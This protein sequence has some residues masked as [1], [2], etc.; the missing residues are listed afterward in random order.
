M[1]VKV[2]KL[3]DVRGYVTNVEVVQ[4]SSG[5]DI[6]PLKSKYDWEEFIFRVNN[7]YKYLRQGNCLTEKDSVRFESI[8]IEVLN[9]ATTDMGGML[10]LGLSTNVAVI[11]IGNIEFPDLGVCN[12]TLDVEIGELL[13]NKEL[14]NKD[15]TVSISV[16]LV[17]ADDIEIETGDEEKGVNLK[18][19]HKLLTSFNCDELEEHAKENDIEIPSK[20]RGTKGD[21]IAYIIHIWKLEGM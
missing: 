9:R 21:M 12:V 4:V 6:T 3:I 20:Y 15:D 11:N 5:F 19:L 13:Y 7:D 16:R 18:E 1:S 8:K 2:D 10:A 14:V 17:T